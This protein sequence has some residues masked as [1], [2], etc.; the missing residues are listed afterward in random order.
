MSA[1]QKFSISELYQFRISAFLHFSIRMF[2]FKKSPINP[3]NMQKKIQK[4]NPKIHKKKPKTKK[5]SK[6]IKIS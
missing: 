5:L 3:N 4:K 6:I 1:I 2:L